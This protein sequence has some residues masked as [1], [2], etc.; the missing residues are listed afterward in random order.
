MAYLFSVRVL[1]AVFCSFPNCR[2]LC[3]PLLSPC[4]SGI[5]AFL[6]YRAA[7]LWFVLASCFVRFEPDW[8]IKQY[9][10]TSC[11]GKIFYLIPLPLSRYAS[12]STRFLGVL[13]KPR[14]YQWTCKK[15]AFF[16]LSP[17]ALSHVESCPLHWQHPWRREC[18]WPLW[19]GVSISVAVVNLLLLLYSTINYTLYT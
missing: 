15:N 6:P 9:H 3:E 4:L 13:K 19:F 14:Q 10:R 17:R 8:K 11:Q 18:F 2:Q 12:R 5:C 7:W 1:F 16:T